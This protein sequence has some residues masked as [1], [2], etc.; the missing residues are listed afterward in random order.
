MSRWQGRR[1]PRGSSPG[2]GS[3]R[4]RR[5]PLRVRPPAMRRTLADRA[6]VSASARPAVVSWSV[7]AR[8]LD[9]VG[10]RPPDQLSRCEETVG[11]VRMSVEVAQCHQAPVVS[12]GGGSHM[13]S[14]RSIRPGTSVVF[15]EVDEDCPQYSRSLLGGRQ[16]G[17]EAGAE[18]CE[19]GVRFRADH[20]SRVR[21]TSPDR[22]RKRC[23][24]AGAGRPPSERACA[25]PRRQ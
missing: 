20:G 14:T 1:G 9:T 18:A 6:A 17:G 24:E 19:Y 2:D 25:C 3:P 21:R 23:P 10:G 11:V 12:V 7:T 4:R 15:I 5:R 8:D 22:S 16:A 13:R